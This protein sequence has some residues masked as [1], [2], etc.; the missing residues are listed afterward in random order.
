MQVLD[1]G[2]GAGLTYTARTEGQ[3]PCTLTAPISIGEDSKEPK[4]AS[5]IS[6]WLW[7][8][9]GIFWARNPANGTS[10]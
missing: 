3:L 5:A 7:R 8:R 6:G 4:S 9:G 1:T 2:T 10:L